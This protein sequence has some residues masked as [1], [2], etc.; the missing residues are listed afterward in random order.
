MA[1]GSLIGVIIAIQVISIQTRSLSEY[2]SKNI[3][4]IITWLTRKEI[5]DCYDLN[6]IV[7]KLDEL[8]QK[9]E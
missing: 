7:E 9:Y 2:N 6:H 8:I 1:G 4:H 3:E 5:D